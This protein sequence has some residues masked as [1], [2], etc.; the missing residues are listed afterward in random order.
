MDELSLATL[1]LHSNDQAQIQGVDNKEG[2]SSIHLFD[3][4]I[5]P[6]NDGD[7]YID[8][9]LLAAIASI[10][11]EGAEET[12]SNYFLSADTLDF[13][14][15]DIEGDSDFEIEGDEGQ[16]ELL[17]GYEDVFDEPENNSA[18]ENEGVDSLQTA[19]A[20]LNLDCDALDAFSDHQLQNFDNDKH[21]YPQD[22]LCLPCIDPEEPVFPFQT[23]RDNSDFIPDHWL[24]QPCDPRKGPNTF[25]P[26]TAGQLGL[27]TR[28][29]SELVP[30]SEDET[31]LDGALIAPPAPQ[32]DVDNHLPFKFTQEEEDAMEDTNPDAA[33][34]LYQYVIGSRAEA[35]A[36]AFVF[37]RSFGTDI[38]QPK[39]EQGLARPPP[40]ERSCL[41]H[42]EVIYGLHFSDCGQFMATASQ[43]ATIRIWRSDNN[44]L[45]ST[46]EGHDKT[47]EC[48]RVAWASQK[49]CN[50]DDRFQYILASGGANGIVK[51]WA[52]S[53]V[54]SD[55]WSCVCTMDHA[56][57]QGRTMH[58]SSS[59]AADPPQVYALQFIDNWQGLAG[60][61]GSIKNSFLMT[62]SDDFIHLWEI[63]TLPS[64]QSMQLKLTEVMSIRFTCLDHFGYGVSVSRVTS[65]GIN[66]PSADK[67]NAAEGGEEVD[68]V[69]TKPQPFGGERNPN[70]LIFVFDASY[71][72]E[73]GLLGVALS[74]GSLRLVNGRGVCV[75]ILQLPGCQS[76]LTSFSWDETGLRL[77]SCVATGHLI[78]W[79]LNMGDGHGR[80]IP[81]CT[82][83]LE[84]GHEPGR[85]LFG[86]RYCGVSDEDLVVSWG[87][88]GKLCLWDSHSKGN[89][90]APISTLI[91]KPEYPIYAVDIAKNIK[92]DSDLVCRVGV[93]G[94]RE[95]LFIG[96]PVFM[97]DVTQD[98]RGIKRASNVK[99]GEELSSDDEGTGDVPVFSGERASTLQNETGATTNRVIPA[100]KQKIEESLLSQ[101]LDTEEN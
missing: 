19:I 59:E 81:S 41:G 53:D 43:D 18:V 91:T 79:S 9:D 77:A 26:V 8:D 21:Y 101:L 1:T 4:I 49:W 87:V 29:K 7:E 89:I 85:P 2:Q 16:E 71:C 96:I 30:I 100:S 45:V 6:L 3:P 75:S 15:F 64:K 46:L 40:Q 92:E 99:D 32:E 31:L 54:F 93:G 57:L 35:V 73:N 65:H 24:C 42:K 63:D 56:A 95:E 82:A 38:Y 68:P 27:S 69:D 58:Q 25:S 88:D 52:T 48:L 34:S 50:L 36:A 51:I 80:V 22:W 33:Q 12:A 14:N 86:S 98:K 39:H 17:L 11:F 70:N 28:R 78:L 76:H 37:T 94:G 23:F 84:G 97:Y 47:S 5:E 44:T 10:D 13:R 20:N 61:G 55:S 62:S 67:T 90:H 72:E 60:N 74:D 66:V 83:V